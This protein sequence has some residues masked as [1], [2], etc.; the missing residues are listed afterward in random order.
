METTMSVQPLA[1]LV[2]PKE[3]SEISGQSHI[4]GEKGILRRMLDSGR[5]S[6]MIFYGPPGIG[7]TTVARIIAAK[8][9]KRLCH[10]N[11]TT[12]SLAD[13]KAACSE[14]ENLFG[15]N[16]VLLYLD[17]IQ[18]F[19]KKQQQSL[20]EYIEDG[21][22]TLIASTTENPYFYVYPAILSRCSVFEFKPV[23]PAEM[24][25]TLKR[26][27]DKDN[28]RNSRV[29]TAEDRI[30]LK[31]AG[32]GAGDV[33][34]SIGILE[35]AAATSDGEITD[36]TVEAL[37][38]GDAALGA[39]DKSDTVHY[40]LLS[41]LQKS[42]RG[43]DPDAAI[44]YAA[45]LL[46]GG[47]LISVCRRLQ[48]IASEDIGAAYPMAAS[49]VHACVSS[50]RELGLPEAKIPL[51]NAVIMLATAPKSNSAY[52]A[53]H[54]AEADIASGKG[55]EIPHHL[56]APK[57]DGYVYPHD[58]PYHYTPQQYLPDD[59]VGSKYYI[60]GDNKTENAAK[61]YWDKIKN[62]GKK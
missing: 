27:L 8:S 16:G 50:A 1:D 35:N 15:A 39:F 44:F 51:A 12:A 55:T 42:I 52:L 53:L 3:L 22:V 36:D 18:Y 11:A 60:P 58:F 56:K 25:P 59:L 31:I 43:S 7:K 23:T 26:A 24:L 57:F 45:K 28:E 17:E 33:R 21:R 62:N 48:V 13:V 19:N 2:R 61:E 9:D 47:D 32:Y 34:R 38:C 54:A 40:D 29:I 46:E 4:C 5:L 6:N 10:L 49:I 20:L 41:G 37:V 14:S 30:L